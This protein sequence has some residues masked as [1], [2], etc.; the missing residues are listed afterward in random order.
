VVAALR[1]VV[2]RLSLFGSRHL[3][4]VPRSLMAIHPSF[5]A[6]IV[7]I[8]MSDLTAEVII[9]YENMQEVRIPSALFRVSSMCV[10]RVCVRMGFV[11]SLLMHACV[12]HGFKAFA[13]RACRSF[14]WS[15]CASAC[16]GT[17]SWQT[18]TAAC[19]S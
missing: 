4:L 7:G 19:A 14:G 2:S 13:L 1:Q 8:L 16:A 11:A 10:S 3:Y 12:L 5:D 17:R 6:V 15:R 18:T 9:L